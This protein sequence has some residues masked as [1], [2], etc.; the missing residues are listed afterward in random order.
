MLES[1]Q[2]KQ[3]LRLFFRGAKPRSLNWVS[4]LT[5]TGEGRNDKLSSRIPGNQGR[6]AKQ[7][8]ETGNIYGCRRTP[9]RNLFR[10]EKGAEPSGI[11]PAE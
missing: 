3:V 9:V 7:R 2:S 8:I 10:A 6:F 4:E 11:V 1:E 5:V